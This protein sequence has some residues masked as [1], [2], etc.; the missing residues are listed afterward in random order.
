MREIFAL[1]LPGGETLRSPKSVPTGGLEDGGTGQT[2]I[3]NS[4]TLLLVGVAVLS[5]IF[6]IF[7]GIQWITA[8]GD[9]TKLDTARKTIIYSLVGLIISFL[10]FIIV[11]FVGSRFGITFFGA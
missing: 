6:L 3:Q 2:V 7:G 1:T 9:K 4:I 5:V 10:S 8:S 11:A